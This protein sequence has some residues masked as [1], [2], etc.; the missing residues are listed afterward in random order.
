MECITVVDGSRF[1]WLQALTIDARGVCA[2]Q[3]GNGRGAADV[4]DGGMDTRGGI[5]T[6][7]CAQVD[8]W[9]EITD[10]VIAASYQHPLSSKLHLFTITENQFAPGG[11]RIEGRLATWFCHNRFTCRERLRSRRDRR[12]YRRRLRRW[13]IGWNLRLLWRRRRCLWLLYSGNIGYRWLGHHR[14]L[15]WYRRH[16]R[17]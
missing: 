7:H 17:L 4:F 9:T 11:C 15:L 12:L 16:I 8:F 13:R 10:I 3:V 6:L 14:W 2:V 5:C 1:V